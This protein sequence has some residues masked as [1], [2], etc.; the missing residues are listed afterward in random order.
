MPDGYPADLGP[1]PE[2]LPF[3]AQRLITYILIKAFKHVIVNAKCKTLPYYHCQV[4]IYILGKL[5][6]PLLGYSRQ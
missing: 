2:S 4:N 5:T 3:I 1:T 6:E